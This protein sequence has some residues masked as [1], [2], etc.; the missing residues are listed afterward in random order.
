[1]LSGSIENKI[2]KDENVQRYAAKGKTIEKKIERGRKK[3]NGVEI[4]VFC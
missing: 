3:K 2:E 1:M 4:T